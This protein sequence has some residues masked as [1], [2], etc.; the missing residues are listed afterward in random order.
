MRP[1]VSNNPVVALRALLAG[2]EVPLGDQVYRLFQAGETVSLPSGEGEPTRP[3]LGI[4]LMTEDK[5]VFVGS[6][7]SLAGFIGAANDLPV[8]EIISLV[9]V[10]VLQAKCKPRK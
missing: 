10:N 8:A 5:P 9:A 6:E 1:A 3:W 2:C 7:L 4:R